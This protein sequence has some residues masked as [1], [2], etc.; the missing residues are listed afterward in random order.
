[1]YG[2]PLCYCVSNEVLI[3]DL[4]IEVCYTALVGHKDRV[5]VVKIL[6]E[7]RLLSGGT[8]QLLSYGNITL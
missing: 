1:M 6:S 4:T 7:N 8:D 5:N 3:Y 2:S